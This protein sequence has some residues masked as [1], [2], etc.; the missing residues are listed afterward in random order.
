[1][2]AG[3]S[4]ATPGIRPLLPH[5]DWWQPCIPVPRGTL[6]GGSHLPAP[7]VFSALV[8][9]PPWG[10]S[11]EPRDIDSP[12]ASSRLLEGARRCQEPQKEAREEKGSTP[13]IAVGRTK[14]QSADKLL[15]GGT[16][17]PSVLQTAP[18]PGFTD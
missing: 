18:S 1:M 15:L 16:G 12:P 5:A 4:Q 2:T 14:Q 7:L 6:L 11:G 9:A 3:Q 13:C 8:L 17:D 10:L